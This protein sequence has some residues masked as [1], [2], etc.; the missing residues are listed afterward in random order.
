MSKGY[1]VY[2]GIEH[3]KDPIASFTTLDDA[4]RL[5]GLI[6]SHTDPTEISGVVPA[7]I[8][9]FIPQ[10]NAG[11]IPFDVELLLDGTIFEINNG[12]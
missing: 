5:S 3:L 2:S 11:L 6:S 12:W 7:D 4:N 1:Y 8:D 10:L 9:K